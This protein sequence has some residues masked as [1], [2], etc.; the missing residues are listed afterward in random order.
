MN[1]TLAV[2]ALF[3]AILGGGGVGTFIQLF[4]FRTDRDSAIAIGAEAAVQS[5]TL[6]LNKADSRILSLEG[7][8]KE[9]ETIIVGLERGIRASQVS[10]E[11]LTGQLAVTNIK[12]DQVLEGQEGTP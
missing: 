10:S 7:K 6:A 12:L 5:L 2:A 3:G 9:L 11:N 8:I 4:R 1:S